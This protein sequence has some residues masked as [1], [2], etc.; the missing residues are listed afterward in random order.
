MKRSSIVLVLSMLVYGTNFSQD[1]L[2]SQYFASQPYLNPAMTGFFDGSYRI[3]VQARNQWQGISS[4]I[5]TFGVS[6]DFKFGDNDP[7]K[8]YFAVG[9]SLYADQIFK[10]VNTYNGRVTA[11]YTKRLGYGATAHYLSIGGNFGQ[12][13]KSANTNNLVA[14]N[15][16]EESFNSSEKSANMGLGLNYQ[17]VFPSFANVFFGVSA[18]HLVSN[19]ASLKLNSNE[20]FE[21]R[22][23]FYSSARLRVKENRL[24]ILPTFLLANQGS[25]R[26]VNFGVSAQILTRNYYNTKA[27]FQVGL[28]SRL[29]SQAMDAIIPVFRYENRGIQLGISYDHNLSE[30][31]SATGGYGGLEISLGYIGF[32]QR[33]I[34]S[35]SECPDLKNF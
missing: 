15:G 24:F 10:R 30:L 3:N 29:G 4:G 19:N 18:D 1:F 5:N 28:F 13:L 32:I 16:Q 11:S 21:K 25:A 33:I 22:I 14:L 8:D 26:Q 23:T 6:G 27:N 7:E 34:R 2:F 35:R 31:S 20:V 17:I 12:I 9:A